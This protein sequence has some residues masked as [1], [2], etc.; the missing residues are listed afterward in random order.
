M[1]YDGYKQQVDCDKVVL[2]GNAMTIMKHVYSAVH[3]TECDECTCMQLGIT[4][5]L[6]ID[7]LPLILK[8]NSR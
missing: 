4:G 3:G 1:A 8:N 6:N 5:Y 2:V 7:I